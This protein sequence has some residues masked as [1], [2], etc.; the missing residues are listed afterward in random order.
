MTGEIDKIRDAFAEQLASLEQRLSS[1]PGDVGLLSDIQDGIGSVLRSG[2]NGEAEIRRLLQERFES[3]DL[4]K[5][6]F[7]LVRSMLDGYVT[8]RLL[9]SPDEVEYSI[10]APPGARPSDIEDSFRSTVVIQ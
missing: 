2:E 4:R 7:Q 8:E 6:T 9:T 3:G 10:T 5:E 1:T